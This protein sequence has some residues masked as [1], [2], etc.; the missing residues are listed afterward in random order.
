MDQLING[1][2]NIIVLKKEEI[3]IKNFNNL[4]H[5]RS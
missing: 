4:S 5:C 2:V 1:F 3:K